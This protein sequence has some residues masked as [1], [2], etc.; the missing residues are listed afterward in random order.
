M[1]LLLLEKPSYSSQFESE[2]TYT[3]QKSSKENTEDE[4]ETPT[5]HSRMR[6]DEAVKGMPTFEE[7]KTNE[8]NHSK[9]TDEENDTGE[10]KLDVFINFA[11]FYTHNLTER[12]SFMKSAFDHFWHLVRFPLERIAA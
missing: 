4:D 3:K 6:F 10:C 9:D 11:F 12:E 7:P 2:R 5:F 8:T 1:E